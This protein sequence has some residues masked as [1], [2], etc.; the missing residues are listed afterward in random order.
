MYVKTLEDSLYVVWIFVFEQEA[1]KRTHF[2][3]QRYNIF[4][5]NQIVL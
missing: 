5:S 3:I 4:L 1:L 2:V